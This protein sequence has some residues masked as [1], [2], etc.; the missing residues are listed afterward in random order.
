M[1]FSGFN[2][3]RNKK[4][5]FPTSREGFPAFKSGWNR[6]RRDEAMNGTM[7]LAGTRT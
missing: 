6:L 5:A 2:G 7:L 1:I 3:I 4:G